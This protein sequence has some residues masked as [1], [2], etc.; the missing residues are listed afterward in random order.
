MASGAT[1]TYG[2]PYPVSTDP[3][4]VAG[5]VQ[6]LAVQVDTLLAAKAPLDTPALTGVPTA[7]TVSSSDNSTKIATT[8]FVKAQSYLTTTTAAST[9]A[10]IA[11]PTFTGNVTMGA[12]D[13]IMGNALGDRITLYGTHDAAASYALGIESNTLYYRANGTHRWYTGVVADA[14]ASEKFEINSTSVVSAVPIVAPAATTSATSIRLPHGTAPSAPTNGDVW[15]TTIGMYAHINGNTIGPFGTGANWQQNAPSPAITGMLWVD[16]DIDVLYI[17]NGTSWYSPMGVERNAQAASYTLA[18]TDRS[19]LVEISSASAN[20]LTVP[21]DSTAFPVGT[22]V[23]I[24]QTGA[25]QTTI[26]PGSGVTINGTP[27]LKLRAQWSSATLIKRGSN[28]W[29]AIG[30]LAA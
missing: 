6:D 14:G 13:F 22:Q 4:D 17:Y 29:V 12:N 10:P 3:V 8:A 16:S 7:P 24:L 18:L 15:T 11:S 20:T 30:D 9:Y 21:P 27:G 1:P 25:G 5:D 23:T 26:T 28:L 2:I 19:K